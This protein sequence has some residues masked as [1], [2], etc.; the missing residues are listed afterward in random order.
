M[1]NQNE[2]L[3][4]MEIKTG[5][6]AELLGLSDRRIRKMTEEETLVTYKRGTYYL[7][8]AIQ[9]YVKFIR[10]G[11][12]LRGNPE[13][14]DSE[15][16]YQQERTKLVKTQREM[17]ELKLQRARGDVHA[18]SDVKALVGGMIA[19]T[20]SR[21]LDLPNK[22]APSIIGKTDLEEVKTIVEAEVYKSLQSL[23]DY[24]ASVY[25]D[26]AAALESGDEDNENEEDG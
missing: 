20:R 22:V 23:A 2:S 13:V 6:L 19:V 15:S 3:C 4:K 16:S 12:S 7:G 25:A 26:R 24:D 11:G 21:L 14:R 1:S 17:H 5:Q 10:S 18:S 9:A 8:D